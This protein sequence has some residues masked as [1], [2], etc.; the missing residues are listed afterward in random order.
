MHSPQA[1][2]AAHGQPPLT[3][4]VLSSE[5]PRIVEVG[6][7]AE[8]RSPSPYQHPAW[9]RAVANGC[10]RGFRCVGVAGWPGWPGT[11]PGRLRAA[12]R[13]R[14]AAHL[15][16]VASCLFHGRLTH[17]AAWQAHHVVAAQ[18][19]LTEELQRRRASPSPRASPSMGVQP[20]TPAAAASSTQGCQSPTHTAAAYST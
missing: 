12:W 3:R 2:P 8:A 14:V 1:A 17:P 9:Y 16:R 6:D 10:G 19:Q 5:E 18:L 20:P 13:A 15:P 11:R 4:Q 7:D